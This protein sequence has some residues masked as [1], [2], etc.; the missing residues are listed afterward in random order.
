MFG[1][2]RKVTSNAVQRTKLQAEIQYLQRQIRQTKEQFGVTIWDFVE[3]DPG[4]VNTEYHVNLQKIREMQEQIQLKEAQ[5]K[6]L[7]NADPAGSSS[8]DSASE[9]LTSSQPIY[10]ATPVYQTTPVASKP[11]PNPQ[12]RPSETTASGGAADTARLT[13]MF[14]AA[15]TLAAVT[16]T[17]DK[18]ASA[19]VPHVTAYAQQRYT[20]ADGI[21]KLSEDAGTVARVSSA[22]AKNPAAQALGSAIFTGVLNSATTAATDGRR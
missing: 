6:S 1:S 17:T 4:R 15:A 3:T 12:N 16:G 18:V 20:G 14:A 21:Q 5:I 11:L 19:A 2:L 10:Q 22:V 9:S 13:S 7:A 8:A